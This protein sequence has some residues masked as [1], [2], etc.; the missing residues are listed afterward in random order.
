M[1]SSVQLLPTRFV[2]HNTTLFRGGGKN[3]CAPLFIKGVAME[4]TL[5]SR[6]LWAAKKGCSLGLFPKKWKWRSEM[7]SFLFF[8]LNFLKIKL[9]RA[10]LNHINW[11]EMG[12]S[13]D[14]QP[15]LAAYK[16][17]LAKLTLVPITR[18][19]LYVQRKNTSSFLNQ[20]KQA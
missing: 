20:K 1:L 12:K 2:Y 14:E 4:L 17:Q 19:L 13:P 3:T 18:Q 10:P 11:Q 16:L 9:Y 7:R 5:A 6:N 8:P 15:F